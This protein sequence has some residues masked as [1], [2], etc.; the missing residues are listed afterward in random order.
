[1]SMYNEE[2]G[3]ISYE[4]S[5]LIEEL[6]ADIEM[7]GNIDMW[8]FIKKTLDIFIIVDY[9]FIDEEEIKLTDAEIEEG[10]QVVKMKANEILTM[11]E[12]QNSF[13]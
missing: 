9:A 8:A 13:I 4:C 11:L 1:M 3:H 12:E 7:F 6:K 5:A 10:I 2:H